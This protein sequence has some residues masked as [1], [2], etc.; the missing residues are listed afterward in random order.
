VGKLQTNKSVRDVVESVFLE[1]PIE[2]AALT[3]AEP[4][5]LSP[6]QLYLPHSELQVKYVRVIVASVQ[7]RLL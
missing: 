2:K 7:V 5:L 1:N 4:I 6:V 3:I